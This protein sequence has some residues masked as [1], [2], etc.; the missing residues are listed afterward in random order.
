MSEIQ[1]TDKFMRILAI[2]G[3]IIAIVESFLE[4]IGFGLM[5]WGFNW[6]SGLLGLLF[7]VLA[8]LLGFKPIHYAP[9]ILGILGI[10]LIVFGIL[11]GGIII[12]LAAFM[13]AL[14]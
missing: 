11:I 4:L 7:A 8:I 9:V 3:G 6:I 12:F 5:P 14:S 2:V 1:A 13:G 10:L